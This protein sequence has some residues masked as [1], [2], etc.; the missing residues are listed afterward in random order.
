MPDQA[1]LTKAAFLL[2][3]VVCVALLILAVVPV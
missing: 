2:C 3:A 1:I